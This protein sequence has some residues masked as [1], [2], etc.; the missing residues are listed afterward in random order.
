MCETGF[1]LSKLA[2]GMI[3]G[4]ERSGFSADRRLS[5]KG[6][7]NDVR[8]HAAKRSGLLPPLRLTLWLSG[9]TRGR[10]PCRNRARPHPPNRQSVVCEG[11]RL[12]GIGRRARSAALSH[13]TNAAKGRPKS[14]LAPDFLGRGAERNRLGSATDRTREWT[15]S[16]RIRRDH[17]FR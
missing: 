13:A 12:A 16:R 1:G 2:A 7:E 6:G 15:R 11:S 17:E 14:G 3:L 5:L 8:E 4:L 9:R 10:A